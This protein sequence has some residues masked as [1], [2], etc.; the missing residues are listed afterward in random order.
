MF[1][2]N[3]VLHLVWNTIFKKLFT[4]LCQWQFCIYS[5]TFQL[6]RRCLYH[7]HNNNNTFLN[8]IHSYGQGNWRFVEHWRTSCWDARSLLLLWSDWRNLHR[9]KA[10][11]LQNLSYHVLLDNP[12]CIGIDRTASGRADLSRGR[13]RRHIYNHN[14]LQYTN[15]YNREKSLK[16]REQKK[17]KRNSNRKDVYTCFTNFQMC[18]PIECFNLP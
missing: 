4:R 17:T 7:I 16:G 3:I 5:I 12:L 18:K 9:R 2:T 14:W 10:R 13:F 11:T 15:T 1:K 8:Q 6:L